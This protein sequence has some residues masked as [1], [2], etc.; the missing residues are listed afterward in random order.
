VPDKALALSVA[1]PLGAGTAGA[2]RACREM[3]PSVLFLD[4]DLD[5][6][7]IVCRLVERDG[8]RSCLALRT[9]DDMR[10]HRAEVLATSMAILDVN[11]G[12]NQPSGLDA[13]AWLRAEGY[14]GRIVFLTGHANSHPL[15]ERAM[16]MGG[17]QVFHKPLT[18][19]ALAEIM[20]TH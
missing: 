3:K 12:V 17:A 16:T 9:L 13:C 1:A 5:L 6:L 8:R 19:E 2:P 7:E 20:A 10:A 18:T 4:D 15:V 11:L 14:A